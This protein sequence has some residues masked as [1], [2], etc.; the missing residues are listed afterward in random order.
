MFIIHDSGVIGGV[1]LDHIHAAGSVEEEFK[2]FDVV[3]IQQADGNAWIG[4]IVQP[5]RN[6]LASGSAL[7]SDL[8]DLQAA[9]TVQVW[10]ILILGAYE[11]KR[12]QL[13]RRRPL[14]GALVQKLNAEDVRTIVTP[15][16][17]IAG[18]DMK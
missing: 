16:Y 5:N 12:L 1:D 14:P 6:I 8:P 4:Q 7:T 13:A 2:C 9:E 11:Q 10:D 3:R 15:P 17:Q 18:E